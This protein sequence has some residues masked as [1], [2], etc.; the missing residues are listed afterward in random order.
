MAMVMRTRTAKV[1]WSSVRWDNQFHVSYLRAYH[2]LPIL[3][4]VV[5]LLST[6]SCYY[7]RPQFLH[8]IQQWA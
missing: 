5:N 6:I 8:D 2:M 7:F 4:V 1:R 3:Y